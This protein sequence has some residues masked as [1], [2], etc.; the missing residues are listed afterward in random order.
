M[1][2][3]EVEDERE[4]VVDGL[5]LGGGQTAGEIFESFDVD[6]AK[7]LDEHPRACVTKFDLWP[8]CRWRGAP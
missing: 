6:S 4:R 3:L 7:L 8:E 2:R 5:L 1:R